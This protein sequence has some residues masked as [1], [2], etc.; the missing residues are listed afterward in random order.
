MASLK[1]HRSS[2]TYLVCFRFGGRQFTKSLKT[3][4]EKDAIAHKVRIEETIRLIKSGRIT[5]PEDVDPG[6]FI[7]SD[8]RIDKPQVLPERVTLSKMFDFYSETLPPGAKEAN[9]L[10]GEKR[11]CEHIVRLLGPGKL[12]SSINT[13]TIQDYVLKRAKE[14]WR[15]KIVSPETIKKELTT[16]RLIWNWCKDRGLLAGTTPTR[17][18]VLP[19]TAEKPRFMTRSEIETILA[20]GGVSEDEETTLWNSLFLEQ[21]EV[22][23]LLEYVK[24]H[25]QF[26]FV[27]PMFVF[28]AHTG[29][30]A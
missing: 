23:E 12:V 24:T 9:T 4:N 21:S 5:L 14:D 3:K 17:G 8:G 30:Q 29:V 1:K 13:N 16:F 2:K 7:L 10:K 15:G 27:Y 6:D 22:T 19:K 25:A 28:V 11:H 26:R 20:R 18:V